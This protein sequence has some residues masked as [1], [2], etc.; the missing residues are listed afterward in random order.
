MRGVN[1]L[2]H[3]PSLQ[4]SRY[5]LFKRNALKSFP[6]KGLLQIHANEKRVTDLILTDEETVVFFMTMFPKHVGFYNSTVS[7]LDRRR[8]N[9]NVRKDM[10]GSE[11]LDFNAKAE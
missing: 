1:Y 6:S 5:K 9:S 10:K 2:I 3:F 4:Q 7:P 8:K 11:P